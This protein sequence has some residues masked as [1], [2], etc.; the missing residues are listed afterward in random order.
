MAASRDLRTAGRRRREYRGAAGV[1]MGAIRGRPGDLGAV[2]RQ[3][4]TEAGLLVL[5]QPVDP[6]AGPDSPSAQATRILERANLSGAVA[7]ARAEL[8]AGLRPVQVGSSAAA[9]LSDSQ[10]LKSVVLQPR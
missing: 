3:P 10:W 9:R 1:H 2:R 5:N 8:A 6:L 4:A 7:L